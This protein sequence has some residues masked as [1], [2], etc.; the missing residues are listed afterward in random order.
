MGF[1][2]SKLLPLALYPLGLGL[3]LQLAGV[4]KHAGWLSGGGVAPIWGFSFPPTPSTFLLSFRLQVKL[5]L[6][7]LCIRLA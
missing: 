6:R 3:L 5:F 1:L 2:L 4:R 7:D